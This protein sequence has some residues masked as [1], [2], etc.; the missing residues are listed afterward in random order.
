MRYAV[1]FTAVLMSLGLLGALGVPAGAVV[2]GDLSGDGR[3]G[4]S[5]VALALRVA[6]GIDPATPDKVAA[7][8]VAPRPGTEGRLYGDAQITVLDVLQLL[9]FVAGLIP[10]DQLAPRESTTLYTLNGRAPMGVEGYATAVDL[11]ALFANPPSAGVVLNAFTT[12]SVPNQ[13]LIR[14]NLGYITNS[15]SNTLQVVNLETRQNEGQP[16]NLGEGTNP[17]QVALVGSKAYVSLLVPNQV[18]V[19]DLEGRKVLNKIP[20]GNSPGGVLATRGKVYVANSNYTFDPDTG[21]LTYGP[22]TVTVIDT[23]TDTVVTTINVGTNPQDLALDSL[24]RI[25]VTCTGDFGAVTGTISVISPVTDE[26]VGTV[27]L[28]GAPGNLAINFQDLAYC[29]DSLNG[30]TAYNARTLEVILPPSNA[31]RFTGAVLDVATDA[32]GRIYGA[33]FQKD[34]V[35]VIDPATNQVLFEVPVGSGPEALAVW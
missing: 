2:P 4:I 33:D 9:R 23:Q 16:L 22:G 20:V 19:V 32:R 24:G 13:M 6:A 17:Y 28:G 10:E 29:A 21:R 35:K 26:V 8:D 30:L 12:G 1:R 15:I 27:A 7:G 25:H 31:I 34:L 3:V 11:A 14:G 18:A 5:D